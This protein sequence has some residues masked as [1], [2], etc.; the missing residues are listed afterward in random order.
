MCLTLGLGCG[1]RALQRRSTVSI[2]RGCF[3]ATSRSMICRIADMPSPFIEFE[4]LLTHF[5]ARVTSSSTSSAPYV[6]GSTTF[7]ALSRSV[8]SFPSECMREST[9]MRPTQG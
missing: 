9:P 5:A 2:D 8:S 4:L 7:S 6:D 3:E 1:I